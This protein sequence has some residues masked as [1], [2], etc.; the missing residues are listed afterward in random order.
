MKTK[1]WVIN[2]LIAALYVTVTGFIA[3]LS[4]GAYQ[5]RIGE[6]LNHLVVFN[7]KYIPGIVGGVFL[8]NLLF[9]EFGGY[10]L[11]FGVGHTILSLALVYLL[12][13]RQMSVRMKMILNTIS[14]AVMSF[15][16]AWMLHIAAAAPF[17][18]TYFTV[19]IGELAVMGLG[20]P[21]MERIEHRLHLT[22]F[23]A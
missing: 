7:K 5:F 13:N 18:F 15:M 22:E 2:G 10:D 4:F 12:T 21:I 11:I 19:A 23:S 20:I 8:S 1:E 14:F 6:M 9:S 16:V 17:W 3:P